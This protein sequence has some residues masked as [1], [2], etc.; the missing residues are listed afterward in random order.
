MGMSMHSLIEPSNQIK[1]LYLGFEKGYEDRPALGRPSREVEAR[2]GGCQSHFPV[3]RKN[4]R[5]DLSAGG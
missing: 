3:S 4:R 2:Y 1:S 5:V